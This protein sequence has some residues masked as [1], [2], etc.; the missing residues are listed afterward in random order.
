MNRDRKIFS[1]EES[2][3]DDSKFD[4]LKEFEASIKN[5]S[6]PVDNDLIKYE[7]AVDY[8]A[9]IKS[10]KV[11]SNDS[12]DHAAIVMSKIFKYSEKEL[13][14]YANNFN[15]AVSSQKKYLDSLTSFIRKEGRISL[16]YKSE[17][18]DSSL[19]YQMIKKYKQKFDSKVRIKQANGKFNQLIG[20]V[21]NEDYH[22]AIGDDNMLRIEVK[23]APVFGAFVCFN[24]KK[25]A[26]KLVRV[27][28]EFFEEA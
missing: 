19:A 2:T 11:F 16:V 18:D 5:L 15:G 22:F 4:F 3:I 12:R 25:E 8:M 28:D 13:R 26:E 10:D 7:K 6:D 21:L 27:F 24:S 14:I 1:N 23:P 17:P 9:E 20:T